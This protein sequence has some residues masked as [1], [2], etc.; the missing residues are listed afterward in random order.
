MSTRMILALFAVCSLSVT[1]MYAQVPCEAHRL[2]NPTGQELVYVTT[3]PTPW[4][5]IKF[6]VEWD[7]E[8]DTA[9]V[10][11]GVER[12]QNS[13]LIPDTLEMRIL[14]DKLPSFYVLDQNTVVIPPNLHGLVPDAYYIMEFEFSPPVASVPG[15]SRFWLSWRLRGPSGDKARIRLKYPAANARRSVV[16][17]A[18]GDTTIA[19]VFVKQALG[20]GRQ[21]S[22]DLWGEVR[23]CYP[24][25][26]PVELSAFTAAYR[27]GE[28]QLRWET[29]TETN[30]FGFDIERLAASSEESGL[31][32]WQRI[33]FV[34][35]KGTTTEPHSYSFVDPT[36]EDAM[37]S[38][39]AVYY[40]L[41]QIDTDGT[42]DLSHVA[43]IQ[44]PL[45]TGF[46]L[47]QSYPNP[48]SLANG[49]TTL[50]VQ[51]AQDGPVRIEM[52][53]ALGRHVRTLHDGALNAGRHF[54]DVPLTGLRTGSY[55]Y[56]LSAG[57]RHLTRRLLITE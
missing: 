6:H 27:A 19:T 25:G 48:A 11:F 18:A 44:I 23:V 26:I 16:I 54:V 35:G 45:E 1:T 57:D 7:A 9:F 38:G 22:V 31:R 56:R 30:N 37:Q 17:G 29:A 46:V 41:R 47:E 14:D 49:R 43:Q 40:R 36:P 5:G 24:N 13:G 15:D 10:A 12:H 52:Y 55:F 39:G 42:T 21:D 51:L 8:V 53:D 32:I 20:L 3:M 28:A 33:G 50:I 34:E 2:F 4:W